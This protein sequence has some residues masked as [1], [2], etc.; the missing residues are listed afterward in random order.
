MSTRCWG[1][2]TR[3]APFHGLETPPPREAA[4]LL[5]LRQVSSWRRR[6]AVPLRP[7]QEEVE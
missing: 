7:I 2:A 6:Q 4:D 1:Q 5:L 3:V